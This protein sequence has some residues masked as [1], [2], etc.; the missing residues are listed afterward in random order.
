MD[1]KKQNEKGMA[2]LFAIIIS[3][4]V[5]VLGLG[6]TMFS[7]TE[8]SSGLEHDSHQRGFAIADGGYNMMKGAL[9]GQDLTTVLSTYSNV[10]GYVDSEAVSGGIPPYRNPVYPIDARNI[11]FRNPPQPVGTF[12]VQGLL[13]PASGTP[14]GSGHFFARVSDNADG[15]S[16]LN[17]DTDNSVYLRVIGVHPAPLSEIASHGGNVKNSVSVIEALLKRNFN[18]DLGA[19]LSLPGPDVDVSFEGAAFNI[20]GDDE[21]PGISVFYD[22]P[23]GSGAAQSA[24]SIYDDLAANKN[25]GRR[26]KGVEG[27]F[28]D[29]PEP[30]IRDDSDAILNSPNPED[31]KVMDPNFLAELVQLLSVSADNYYSD[32]TVL[33]GSIVELGTIDD[34]KVT[35]ADGDLLLAGRGTGAGVLVVTGSLDYQGAFDFNGLVLVL[36]DGDVKMGGAV[37]D[38]TGG[39]LVS[40]LVPLEGGGY[41]MGIPSAIIAG[42]STFIFDGTSLSLAISLLPL[43][44]I[45]WREITP[46]IEPVV[47]SN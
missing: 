10:P 16:D 44:T 11:D 6:L 17:F 4:F 36:G 40:K 1:I 8:Y 3:L 23:D 9:R 41:E 19:P 43:Q 28:G 5:T 25:M 27:D 20:I 32:G 7:I 2:L 14:L 39:M 47:A 24:Q 15:D 31:K 38:I 13:T 29:A 22:A 26:I 42:V 37:K 21:H 33:S 45:M 34:P 18:F 30:S 46:D 12:S 35:F